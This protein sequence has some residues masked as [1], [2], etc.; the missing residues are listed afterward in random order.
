MDRMERKGK[1]M[2][3]RNFT[4]GAVILALLFGLGSS[5][6]QPDKSTE[7]MLKTQLADFAKVNEAEKQKLLSD[8]ANADFS[9]CMGGNQSNF[10]RCCNINNSCTPPSS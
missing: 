4:Q 3:Y 5:C 7:A 6:A 2:K 10:S 1:N 9:A 8:K